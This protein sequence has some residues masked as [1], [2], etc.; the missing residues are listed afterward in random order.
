MQ[1]ISINVPQISHCI[2]E[3]KLWFM[4]YTKDK[5]EKPT[6]KLEERAPC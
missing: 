2:K 6:G 1:Q 5:K 4:L 3:E